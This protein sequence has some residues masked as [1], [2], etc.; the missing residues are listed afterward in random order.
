MLKVKGLAGYT[1]QRGENDL[2]RK[3]PIVGSGLVYRV[4]ESN[5]GADGGQS[6]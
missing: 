3:A 1:A 6:F 5:P 4:G 2:N